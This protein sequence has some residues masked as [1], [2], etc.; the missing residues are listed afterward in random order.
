MPKKVKVVS[1]NDDSTYADITDAV[2]ENEEAETTPTEEAVEPEPPAPKVRAKRVPKP[3]VVADS[4]SEPETPPEVV[5]TKPKAKRVA[6]VKVVEPPLVVEPML[7]DKPK[8]VR[9]PRVK[10][11]MST[12]GPSIVVPGF[13]PRLTRTAAREA[14]YQSPASNALG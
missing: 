3:K 8:A 2:I 5:E 12:S 9:K 4:T 14:L 6:K 1:V 11:E 10:K 7:N 13:P